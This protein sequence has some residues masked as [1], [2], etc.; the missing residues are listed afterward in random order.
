MK[1]QSKKNKTIKIVIIVAV[2]ILLI[3]LVIGGILLFGDE[4][5]PEQNSTD[6]VG[7][8]MAAFPNREYFVGY[9]LDPVG[10]K[11]QVLTYDMKYTRFVD[12]TKLSFSG[13]DSS[14]PVDEQVITVSY[15]GFST[16]FTVKIKEI[17]S[18]EPK[19]QSIRLSDNF[20]S[21]YDLNW[22]KEY[23]PV[24]DNVDLICTYTDGSEKRVPMSANYCLSINTDISG[25]T[26]VEIPV[27][28]SDAGVLVSTTVIVTIT[29]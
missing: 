5:V 21:T 13:F 24:F 3:G 28:Y 4:P 10:T 22:W 14:A 20:V 17:P 9:D 23:G 6:I 25:P 8:S 26:T 27:E 2:A 12:H 1:L 7:I 16:T 19:L 18:A 15:M 11:I 29:D